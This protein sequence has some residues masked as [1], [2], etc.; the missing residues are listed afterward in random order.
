[1]MWMNGS[2]RGGL[3]CR[4]AAVRA[5]MEGD[6]CGGGLDDKAMVGWNRLIFED[7]GQTKII[8]VVPRQ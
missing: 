7:K 6:E 8:I 3:K 4:S 2:S 5:E 1:M